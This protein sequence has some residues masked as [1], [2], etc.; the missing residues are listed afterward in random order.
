MP[1]DV[2]THV[3]PPQ[4]MLGGPIRA[5]HE[6]TRVYGYIHT[7]HLP[8]VADV[9][10]ISVAEVRG[11]VSFYE[12]FKT[13]PPAST[14]IRVCQAEACQAV[15][16]RELTHELE[17]AYHTKLGIRGNDVELEA[18]YCLGLCASGPA[19]QVNDQ[20]IARASVAKLQATSLPRSTSLWILSQ[21]HWTPTPSQNN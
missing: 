6:L 14:T 17:A 2:R 21:S 11:I 19:V 8:T 7:E 4:H 20:L 12:D 9:F 5:L 13:H 10:N 16:S 1:D 18:V 15:G 3:L